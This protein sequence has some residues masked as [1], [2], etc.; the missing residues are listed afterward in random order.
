MATYL[1]NRVS[2]LAEV[3]ADVSSSVAVDS[4]DAQDAVSCLYHIL[5]LHSSYLAHR[6]SRGDREAIIQIG[7]AM[8][9]ALE[10]HS[11]I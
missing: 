3:S 5:Q 11:N 6:D 8:L 7:L 4:Y 1:A 9:K 2:K 10:V